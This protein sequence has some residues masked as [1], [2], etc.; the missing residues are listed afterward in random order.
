MSDPGG[1]DEGGEI[2]SGE[3]KKPSYRL[4]RPYQQ[5]PE[6]AKQYNE[7]LIER[8]KRIKEQ[9]HRAAAERQHKNRK[10][11]PA[12]HG[13]GQ[14]GDGD[15]GYAEEPSNFESRNSEQRQGSRRRWGPASPEYVPKEG[16]DDWRKKLD[17]IRRRAR[18]QIEESRRQRQGRGSSSEQRSP[19]P[20]SDPSE[21][22]PFTDPRD[23]VTPEPEDIPAES[24][25][26]PG[27]G[28]PPAADEPPGSPVPDEDS[29]YFSDGDFSIKW[30]RV[31][32][33]VGS[34]LPV[35][36]KYFLETEEKWKQS[37][38]NRMSQNEYLTTTGEY[39][40]AL[41]DV[42]LELLSFFFYVM[43]SEDSVERTVL[44]SDFERFVRQYTFDGYNRFDR[45]P[46]GRVMYVHP[47]KWDSARRKPDFAAS[48]PGSNK[49][50]S[51]GKRFR[52]PSVP[53]SSSESEPDSMVLSDSD[54]ED[55]ILRPQPPSD[56]QVYPVPPDFM[57]SSDSEAEDAIPRPQSPSDPQVYPV[58]AAKGQGA[59]PGSRPGVRISYRKRSPVRQR[60]PLRRSRSPQPM[61][62][63]GGG[64]LP[65]PSRL[66]PEP[67]NQGS[68][69]GPA[70]R[71]PDVFDH[72][73]YSE[74]R[75]NPRPFYPPP[76]EFDDGAYDNQ[77]NSAADDRGSLLPNSR[78]AG[79]RGFFDSFRER[80]A[81]F[82][83][84]AGNFIPSPKE[85]AERAY[86]RLHDMQ[87]W[88]K[89][90]DF[91]DGSGDE[92]I[93]DDEIDGRD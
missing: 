83:R 45:K 90:A 68:E 77:D 33:W 20:D 65:T 67:G 19:P 39:G 7:E 24:R 42:S 15:E 81:S 48:E 29:Q 62:D 5:N 58:P 21:D 28:G 4:R 9:N 2:E 34:R 41:K 72:E 44:R 61:P 75:E 89:T 70:R 88:R 38:G 91:L 57:I 47:E 56:P 52:L 84:G 14:Q 93:L 37:V 3:R 11:A 92:G 35:L 25:S 10:Q 13:R 69:E 87:R 85:R 12:R 63:S 31:R 66:L 46:G 43:G 54:A 40:A 80:G 59:R 78:R 50:V 27:D 6:K 26:D 64:G 76:D 51:G 8:L 22:I 86:R 18:E 79:A 49:E 17:R 1:S 82:F 53:S 74:E 36:M 30:G 32:Y 73:Y 71:V 16:V 60:N 23:G 55:A